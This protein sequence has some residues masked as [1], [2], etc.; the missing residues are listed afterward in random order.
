MIRNARQPCSIISAFAWPC[1]YRL[2]VLQLLRFRRRH[3]LADH[4]E[5]LQHARDLSRERLKF[6]V[7]YDR[8]LLGNT[9]Q[10]YHREKAHNAPEFHAMS[11][12]ENRLWW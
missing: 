10:R 8:E 3:W 12:T 11:I 1:C 4:V 7:V 5:R 9:D 2:R 6:D